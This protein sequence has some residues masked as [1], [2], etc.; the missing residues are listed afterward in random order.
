MTTIA[1]ALADIGAGPVEGLEP[2]IARVK[3]NGSLEHYVYSECASKPV[4]R[5]QYLCS[6]LFRPDDIS[7]GGGRS[8]SNAQ[9]ILW[10]PFDFDLGTFVGLERERIWQWEQH[11]I[12]DVVHAL[13][14]DVQRIFAALQ[15]P[16][17][18][19]DYTGYGLAV[20]IYLPAHGPEDVAEYQQIH[21]ALV[22]RIN[23]LAGEAL[24]DTSVRDAGSRIMRLVPG[25]NDKGGRE[26]QTRTIEY[27]PF[28][29]APVTLE[30]LR[31]AVGSSG[32]VTA[33]QRI[34]PSTGET[35]TTDQVDEIVELVRPC[36]REGFRHAMA[37]GLSGMLAKAGVPESQAIEIMQR[38][39][40]GDDELDDR[41]RA[42][43]TSY[44]RVRSG[45]DVRGFYALRESID[46]EA[47]A[48]VDRALADIRRATGP[49]LIIGE[50]PTVEEVQ[51]A[52]QVHLFEYQ[53]L[54]E[55]ALQGWI[56]EYVGLVINTTEAPAA[57]HYISGMA[58][59]G[60]TIG[61]RIAI[62]AGSGPMY[63]NI[64][65]LLVGR[66]GWSRKD[67]AVR[68][69]TRLLAEPI[70][71]G[72][73]LIHT[74]VFVARNVSSS[75]GLIKVLSETGGN[76]LLELT[77]F[78]EIFANAARQSTATIPTT[79]MRLYDMPMTIENTSKNNPIVVEQPVTTILGATQ[80]HTLAEAMQ[81][82]HISSGF[83][84]RFLYI[85]GD[86]SGPRPMADELDVVA[87][88]QCY[89]RLRSLIES[90]RDG[91]VLRLSPS[92]LA[93]WERWY[94]EH[95]WGA[96]GTPEEDVMRVRHQDHIMKLALIYAVTE[97]AQA[98][99]TPHLEAAAA[100][101][102]WSWQHLRQ[103]M[104]EWG[105]RLD[106]L[107][108]ARIIAAL[109]QRGNMKRRDLFKLCKNRRWTGPEMTRVFDA[110][111]KQDI[112]QVDSQ[113]VVGLMSR[114]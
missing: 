88:Q 73:N 102:A 6:G 41:M 59:A 80:P 84:N 111:A 69:V 52:G 77:E 97:Q 66:S 37:L 101:L 58:M 74:G 60:S 54:P 22:D 55:I 78:S 47:L 85:C 30:Q 90:Y 81:S 87:L 46:A 83:A 49:R 31:E 26:R 1:E 34:V 40:A 68:R 23:T 25:V 112:V 91:A 16:I 15:I 12:D 95:H 44:A 99:E 5:G 114:D 18:R 39:A 9:R 32:P 27:T 63:P 65:A 94:I 33:P 51:V 71:Q 56:A 75:E 43:G 110:M 42:V 3:P 76:I 107:I 113:G 14:V 96:Q 105:Q 8:K 29:E 11:H 100:V 61:R 104:G 45:Q 13:T 86:S 82:L 79:L 24:A 7:R 64:Y 10:L 53:P 48:W 106:N 28:D 70:T 103:L 98:I 89:L 92:A 19:I 36:W 109:E 17:H 93:W 20:Y 4:T 35:L 50:K 67:T 21:S 57:F 108:E 72:T 62:R 2:V 38:V